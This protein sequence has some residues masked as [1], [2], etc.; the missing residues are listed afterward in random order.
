MPVQIEH[1]VPLS[2]QN[3]SRFSPTVQVAAFTMYGL[4][5]LG[6]GLKMKARN[7]STDSS[8]CRHH[9]AKRA[10]AWPDVWMHRDVFLSGSY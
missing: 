9:R 3:S 10:A 2:P 4:D 1:K 6:L 5:L 8:L 7:R